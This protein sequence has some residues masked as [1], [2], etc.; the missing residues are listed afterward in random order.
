M[1][2][3]VLI[4][5]FIF[6]SWAW[7]H[8]GHHHGEHTN[9]AKSEVPPDIKRVYEQINTE[10]ISLMKP[11]FDN[12]CAACHS[13]SV[14]SPWYA[15]IPGVGWIIESDRSEAK[16]HLDFSNGF[17]F[18]GHGTPKE[19]LAAIK[20]VVHKGTMPTWLY[21]FFHPSSRLSR[22]EKE[23]I[24]KWVEASENKMKSQ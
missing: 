13:N 5:T 1:K 17:P 23:K 18:A 3:F 21:S 12:K 6:C 16:E 22:D 8:P 24:L 20:E 11:I 15:K 19:D 2:R 4:F 7:A 14:S 9:S 10:Y